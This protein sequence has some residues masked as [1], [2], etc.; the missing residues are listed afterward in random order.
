M[1]CMITKNSKDQVPCSYKNEKFDCDNH[2]QLKIWNVMT[3]DH[4]KLKCSNNH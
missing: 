2:E 1:L 4:G 3:D